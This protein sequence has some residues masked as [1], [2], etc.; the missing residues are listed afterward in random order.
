MRVFHTLKELQEA[1]RT[2][3]D[4][5]NQNWLLQRHGHRTPDQVRADQ[6]QATI[7][8]AELAVAS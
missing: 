4:W 2:F 3:K 8:K 7:A 1:L 5:Y 6:H